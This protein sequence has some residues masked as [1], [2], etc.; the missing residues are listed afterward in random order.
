[1]PARASTALRPAALVAAAHDRA[2]T[3]LRSEAEALADE[4]DDPLESAQVLR[5]IETRRA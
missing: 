5:D 2:K 1:M 4:S 3:K